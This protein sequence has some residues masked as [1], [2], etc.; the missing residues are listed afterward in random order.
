MVSEAG[1]DYV[2]LNLKSYNR[3]LLQYLDQQGLNANPLKVKQ[4]NKQQTSHALLSRITSH[5]LAQTHS[6]NIDVF[7]TSNGQILFLPFNPWRRKRPAADEASTSPTEPHQETISMQPEDYAEEEDEEGDGE[8][9]LDASN[10]NED[11]SNMTCHTFC[12]I[13]KLSKEETLTPI[14]RA[15]FHTDAKTRWIQGIPVGHSKSQ[16]KEKYR[17]SR[18]LFWSLDLCHPDCFIPFK[19]P[20]DLDSSSIDASGDSDSSGLNQT[21]DAIYSDVPTQ[22]VRKYLLLNSWEFDNELDSNNKDSDRSRNLFMDAGTVPPP[23]N[24]QP[25]YYIFLMPVAFPINTPE[26][27]TTKLGSITHKM[28]IQIEKWPY[29]PNLQPPTASAASPNHHSNFE[30]VGFEQPISRKATLSTSPI[31]VGASPHRRHSVA[32]SL[33][34]KIGLHR[35]T[36]VGKSAP[37][38]ILKAVR[39]GNST[40]TET[41]QDFNYELPA[42]RLPPSD[43]TSTLNKSIYVNRVWNKSLNY[44]LLLPRKYIQL[45]PL[46]TINDQ[47]LRPHEFLLQM[48]LMPLVKELCLKRIKINV[49]EKST[50][51]SKDQRYEED[52]GRVDKSGIKERVVTLLEINARNRPS[53]GDYPPLC[54]QTVKGCVDD[55]L[56]TCCYENTDFDKIPEGGLHSSRRRETVITNPVKIQCPLVFVANDETNFITNVHE[57]LACGAKDLTQLRDS[58]DFEDTSSIFSVGNTAE[59]PPPSSAPED[60]MPPSASWTSKSPSLG[61]IASKQRSLYRITSS[62]DNVN[63]LSDAD[64]VRIYTFSPDTTFHNVKIRHRLQIC[65]RVSKP[66]EFVVT[67]DGPKM[68]HY[69]VIVDT[70]IVFVSPFCVEDTLEL[71]SYDFA[72]KTSSFATPPANN[73]FSFDS[74]NDNGTTRRLPTFEEAILQPGSPMMTGMPNYGTVDSMTLVAQSPP[75]RNV[76]IPMNPNESDF[77][78]LDSLVETDDDPFTKRIVRRRSAVA[79]KLSTATRAPPSQFS[80]IDSALKNENGHDESQSSLLYEQ[81]ELPSYQS[82]IDEDMSNGL[83]EKMNLLDVNGSADSIDTFNDGASVSTKNSINPATQS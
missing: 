7:M 14:I 39:G 3:K 75:I 82:V 52:V 38:S 33:L 76:P 59:V 60:A 27:V 35:Q 70:P 67:A 16:F 43:A 64:K 8:I 41:L 48:K 78:S 40:E 5:G 55:N 30:D 26:T 68:H 34:K 56:L 20:D 71:P 22:S 57:N 11:E 32:S 37:G 17:V 46:D 80:S 51:I 74:E 19:D 25:G 49:V 9:D 65:F 36:S 72:L 83:E 58:V 47:Y 45:S 13:V 69:E 2:R 63:D 81:N 29:A 77:S 15:D 62:I 18:E 24:F 44:E 50:Y 4:P 42:V 6:P 61:P 53:H 31:S 21:A 10:V 23:A 12:V 28:D 79:S 1:P 54:M 66:D 73:G